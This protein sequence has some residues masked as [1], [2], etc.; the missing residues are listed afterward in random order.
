MRFYSHANETHFHVSGC[1]TVFALIE[2]LRSMRKWAF[3]SS[4]FYHLLIKLSS[5]FSAVSKIFADFNCKFSD[6]KD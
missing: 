6:L 4:A 3:N 2:W 5:Y 1:E